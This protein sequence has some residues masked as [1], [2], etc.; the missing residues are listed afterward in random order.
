MRWSETP[1]ALNGGRL[2]GEQVRRVMAI[3][4]GLARL[5]LMARAVATSATRL[6]CPSTAQFFSVIVG[7][8]GFHRCDSGQPA[9]A[10]GDVFGASAWRSCSPR[11]MAARSRGSIE[12]VFDIT[13]TTDWHVAHQNP[14]T[15]I[16]SLSPAGR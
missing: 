3:L 8:P 15:A 12:H 7:S 6:R 16:S 10:G 5:R 11:R 2:G 13:Q 4:T 1:V 14:V 9:G